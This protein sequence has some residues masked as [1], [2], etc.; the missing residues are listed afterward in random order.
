ML[1]TG[2]PTV[3]WKNSDEEVYDK[4]KEKYKILSAFGRVA[5]ETSVGK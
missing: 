3:P 2:E 4:Q 1:Q 5:E